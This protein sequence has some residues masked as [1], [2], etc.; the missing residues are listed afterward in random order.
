M[1]RYFLKSQKGQTAVEY[2]LMLAMGA[3]IG[4]TAFKKLNEYLLTKPDSIIGKPLNSMKVRMSGQNRY[5][6]VP[7]SV[8]K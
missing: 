4:L 3:S 2:L 8:R 1:I 7:F 5:T 6:E